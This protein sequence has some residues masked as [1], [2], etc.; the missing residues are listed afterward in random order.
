[1]S[2]TNKT[3]KKKANQARNKLFNLVTGENINLDTEMKKSDMRERLNN[4]GKYIIKMLCGDFDKYGRLLAWIYDKNHT[5]C[6]DKDKLK[7]FNHV[8]I[9]E[10]LAYLY[11]GNTKMSEE[12]QIKKFV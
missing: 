2:S 9:N 6:T 1:M 12:E 8:L 5:F 4:N 10:K 11:Y 7:S 3:L